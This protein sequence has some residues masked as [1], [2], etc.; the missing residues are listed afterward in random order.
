MGFALDNSHPPIFF[1]C[2]RRAGGVHF[3]SMKAKY[4]AWLESLAIDINPDFISPLCP[5]LGQDTRISFRI[6]S[7]APLRGAFLHVMDNGEYF[8]LPM[9]AGGEAGAFRTWSLSRAVNEPELRFCLILDSADGYFFVNKAGIERYHQGRDS[10]FV[11]LTD[12]R[13]PFWYSEGP[14][15]QIFPDRFFRGRKTGG[16]LDNEY[17]FDGGRTKAMDWGQ[18]PLEWKEAHCLDF[19][20]GDLDGIRKKIAYLKDLGIKTIYLNPIFAART[21]HRYDCVDYFK[22]EPHL[23]GNPAFRRLCAALHQAGLRIVLDVSINHTGSEHPWAQAAKADPNSKEAEFYYRRPDGELESW[24]GVKTLPQLNYKSRKL[25]NIMLEG[26]SSLV[27][28]WLRP[29]YA[30]DGW[31]LDVG[32]MTARRGP[33][34]LGHDVFRALRKAAKEENPECVII[35]EQW[36][37]GAEYLRGDQWDGLMNYA[38]CARPLRSFLGELDRFIHGR[39]V[40]AVMSDN[41]ISGADAAAMILSH[42]A[43]MSYLSQ[44]FSMNAIAT[45]DMYRVQSFTSLYNPRT[46]RGLVCTQFILPGAPSIYYGDEVGLE[47]RAQTTEGYRYPME[48]NK[49][50]QKKEFLSLYKALCAIRCR[51]AALK[52]GALRLVHANDDCMVFAR[53]L[54][55][56]AVLSVFS[57]SAIGLS[58]EV[59]ARA[60]GIHALEEI[61]PGGKAD[62]LSLE[63]D[64]LR[65]RLGPYA[66]GLWKAQLEV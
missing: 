55:R 17:E 49:K 12:Q 52:L 13:P 10:D 47:G 25:W 15:Y 6:G 18:A 41:P 57:R 21:V 28:T 24:L 31:R 58:F 53:V 19:Y 50:K 34:Q 66:S 36:Q 65:F 7:S 54:A 38:A 44:H 22:V 37:D 56:E 60:L 16:V 61:L 11:I 62:S 40:E 20:N 29:P 45:H 63:G 51:E 8:S 26:K 3:I 33:D 30:I 39:G 5:R 48:W 2:E 14:V 59:D 35:G 1:P 4:P 43:R 9:L 32:N 46:Y 23:G 42:Y 27:R 64:L